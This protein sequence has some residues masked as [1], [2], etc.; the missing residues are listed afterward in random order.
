MVIG[1]DEFVGPS[2]REPAMAASFADTWSM[3][4]RLPADLMKRIGDE[5]P[6][7]VYRLSHAGNHRKP[8]P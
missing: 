5:N 6:R 3:W 2:G 4:A 1:S 7:S 8:V